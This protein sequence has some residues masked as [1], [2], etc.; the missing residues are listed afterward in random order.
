[1]TP[2]NQP[3]QQAGNQ[4]GQSSGQPSSNGTAQGPPG[5]GEGDGSAGG[6]Y[7]QERGP[8]Q[9]TSHAE[10]D[11][12]EGRGGRVISSWT[13]DGQEGEATS[14]LTFDQAVREARAEAERAVSEDRTPKRYHKAIKDYFGNL[15]EEAP[16]ASDSAP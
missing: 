11:I 4:P 13:N 12:Q 7:G 5:P 10:R 16:P 2:G 3:G 1:M 14:T 8:L 9:G 6:L 15:P